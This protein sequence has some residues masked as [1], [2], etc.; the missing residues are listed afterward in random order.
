MSSNILDPALAV[1]VERDQKLAAV[2]NFE[3]TIAEDG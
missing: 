2:H 1:T 3:G